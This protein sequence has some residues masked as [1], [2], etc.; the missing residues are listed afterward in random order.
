[1]HRDYASTFES[2]DQPS[3]GWS[4]SQV[5]ELVLQFE[6]SH[7][8]QRAFAQ[9]VNL[10]RSTLQHWLKRKQTLDADPALVAFFE[11][12]TGLAF[13]HR[14]V[15]ACHLT[16]TQQGACGLRPV[17]EFLRRTGLNQFVASSFGSQQAIARQLE[18]AILDY[19][20]S[21]RSLLAAQMMPKPITVCEDETFHPQVCLVSIEPVSD[22]ILLE[23]Y[24]QGRDAA[25]WTTQLTTALEGLPVAVVQVTSDQ[26]KGLLAHARDGLGAHQSPDLFHVQHDVSKATG[27]AL[28]ARTHRAQAE[29]DGARQQTQQWLA[30]RDADAQ[31]QRRPGRPPD[32]TRHIAEGRASA[33]APDGAVRRDRADR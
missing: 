28:R 6:A 22:F 33:A 23:V 11:S 29:L 8:S 14:L 27:L 1:M 4:R 31:G 26:A 9:R 3:P 32:F 30:R 2:V 19:G 18:Q 16:F 24:C 20:A 7:S 21:Q 25:S 17:C 12:P 10:P 15:G 13:L 5:A